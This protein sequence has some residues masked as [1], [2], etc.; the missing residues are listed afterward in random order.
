MVNEDK[1]CVIPIPMTF[2]VNLLDGIPEGSVDEG[3]AWDPAEK[4]R[5]SCWVVTGM[6]GDYKGAQAH[7]GLW[8]LSFMGQTVILFG[9]KQILIM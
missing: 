4:C 8:G 5:Q 2:L 1:A 6:G 9:V 3:L 7:G